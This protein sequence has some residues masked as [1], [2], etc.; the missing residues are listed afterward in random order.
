[1]ESKDSQHETSILV[2]SLMILILVSASYVGMVGVPTL[3][4]SENGGEPYEEANPDSLNFFI[5]GNNGDV[6]Y[7]IDGARMY[8]PENVSSNELEVNM[9]FVSEEVPFPTQSE[10]LALTPHGATF[11]E[12]IT[13]TMD[14]TSPNSAQ[15]AMYTKANADAPW[16]H[17]NEPLDLSVEGVVS[18][19]IT[20][21]SYWVIGQACTLGTT[22][23]S[24]DGLNQADMCINGACQYYVPKS[25]MEGMNHAAFVSGGSGQRFIDPDGVGGT[26]ITKVYCDFTTNGGGW[27]LPF[28]HF[29]TDEITQLSLGRA[30]T[31]AI[32]VDRTVACWGT[33]QHGQFGNGD[34]SGATKYQMAT[35]PLGGQAVDITSGDKHVCVLLHT[36]DIKCWGSN[37]KGQLG[38]T[39]GSFCLLYTSPSPRDG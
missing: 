12:S 15:P 30:H 20:H 17:Y 29:T 22:C 24:P 34:G 28:N 9:A 36:D 33:D 14:I 4:V 32:L 19:D 25:C 5:G 10:V 2:L 7:S 26:P 39:A 31:C 8:A 13:I 37:D 16:I 6:N 27:T 35:L 11:E 38:L 1:M 21:F 3:T 23:P 18:F